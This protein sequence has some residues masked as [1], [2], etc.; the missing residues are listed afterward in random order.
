MP[1]ELRMQEKTAD[2]DGM[3][4]KENIRFSGRKRVS[5]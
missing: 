2:C 3:E 4:Q 1:G 5:E